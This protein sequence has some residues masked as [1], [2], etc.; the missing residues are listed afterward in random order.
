MRRTLAVIAVTLAG[1]IPLGACSG[2]SVVS[3][4][5]LPDSCQQLLEQSRDTV[6]AISRATSTAVDEYNDLPTTAGTAANDQANRRL[7]R[8]AAQVQRSVA[9]F[10]KLYRACREDSGGQAP[11]RCVDA[12]EG[13]SAWVNGYVEAFGDAERALK[14]RLQAVLASLQMN[15]EAA[16]S[17]SDQADAAAD[18]YERQ[19]RQLDR[20]D[21]SQQAA[22]QAC[23]SGG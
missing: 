18:R 10:Q 6:Q 11:S 20:L 17:L 22:E 21:D 15:F 14:L 13:A 16:N 9:D 23:Q 12:L 7:Q 2:G 8:Q 19:L 1:L 5:Q 3:S 4:A